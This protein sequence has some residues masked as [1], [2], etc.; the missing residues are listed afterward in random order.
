MAHFP[1]EHSRSRSTLCEAAFVLSMDGDVS[2]WLWRQGAAELKA[3]RSLFVSRYTLLLAISANLF[4]SGVLFFRLMGTMRVLT[5]RRELAVSRK[6]SVLA[7]ASMLP[8]VH[9]TLIPALEVHR[10]VAMDAIHRSIGEN[11]RSRMSVQM[12]PLRMAGSAGI[13]FAASAVSSV[14]L[15]FC[16][17]GPVGY[18]GA[19]WF[20]GVLHM[21]LAA[22]LELDNL[23]EGARASPWYSSAACVR[24][25][26]HKTTLG[27]DVLLDAAVSDG[28]AGPAL[29]GAAGTSR[30]LALHAAQGDPFGA[31]EL[32]ASPSVRPETALQLWDSQNGRH[33]PWVEERG[34]VGLTIQRRD[35]A[36]VQDVV[37][38]WQQRRLATMLWRIAGVGVCASL[39]IAAAAFATN[40]PQRATEYCRGLT[41]S[42]Y[43]LKLSRISDRLSD[44]AVVTT[45]SMPWLL[46]AAVAA[47][48]AVAWG[49]EGFGDPVIGAWSTDDDNVDMLLEQLRT[50]QDGT[51][52]PAQAVHLLIAMA[53]E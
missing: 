51:L 25:L 52:V 34:M 44:V 33:V 15:P 20:A 21:T 24:A 32:Q 43:R 4:M 3:H 16:G 45:V 7:R 41:G 35:G 40:S 5:D 30:R 22:V 42:T 49:L 29:S 1:K 53:S 9:A 6:G 47:L 18:S 19:A 2:A 39:G 8:R 10:L 23:I 50:E 13:S 31:W 28:M 36:I 38:G 17:N 26:R 11:L 37:I 14:V 46:P 12:H 48:G 27:R